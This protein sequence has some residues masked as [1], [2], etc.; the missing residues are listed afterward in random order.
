MVEK[1][2]VANDSSK[3]AKEAKNMIIDL[4]AINQQD[5]PASSDNM[6]IVTTLE[7]TSELALK[8]TTKDAL[9]NSA[10][11][12]A[13]V[14][15]AAT[16]DDNGEHQT[17]DSIKNSTSESTFESKDTLEEAAAN[18]TFETVPDDSFSIADDV[19][20]PS[21]PVNLS[22]KFNERL[23]TTITLSDE[24]NDTFEDDDDDEDDSVLELIPPT[25]PSSAAN[26][27]GSADDHEDDDNFAVGN[28][29][30][31]F[32][33]EELLVNDHINA[34]HT[35]G[36]TDMQNGGG[37]KEEEKKV[38][39]AESAT[40]E[41]EAAEAASEIV[42]KVT[43]ELLEKVAAEEKLA[44]AETPVTVQVTAPSGSK[45]TAPCKQET[46]CA[47]AGPSTS[48]FV[49]YSPISSGS[50]N[51]HSNEDEQDSASD[52][53]ED[54]F[55]EEEVNEQDNVANDDEKKNKKKKKKNKRKRHR[56]KKKKPQNPGVEA[57][58]G[59]NNENE[60]EERAAMQNQNLEEG[61]IPDDPEEDPNGEVR[62]NA[63]ENAVNG[64]ARD[65]NREEGE[66]AN[67]NAV[68]NPNGE[69]V[70]LAPLGNPNFQFKCPMCDELTYFESEHSLDLHLASAPHNV[71]SYSA[72]QQFNHNKA[73]YRKGWRRPRQ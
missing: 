71:Y 10:M 47:V 63:V 53:D 1:K 61:E 64:M 17:S 14:T 12:P 50:S 25:P 72:F 22:P 44:D 2:E 21:A 45:E 39:V 62:G 13:A 70:V 67:V 55:E 40:A 3:T 65:L 60:N 54:N 5:E 28:A 68:G 8:D 29:R 51:F 15:P 41:V 9:E 66:A 32:S 20:T 42:K 34:E 73:G 56:K 35:A 48:K 57:A 16:V 38:Q 18:Y 19:A 4:V 27:S 43:E 37:E 52:S 49:A 58:E 6:E 7:C 24:K 26:S 23:T 46:D 69:R 30:E 59:A 33:A 36:G 11:M 31:D